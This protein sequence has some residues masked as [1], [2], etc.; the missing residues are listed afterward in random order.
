[1]VRLVALSLNTYQSTQ[2]NGKKLCI[3]VSK[4]NKSDSIPIKVK[5]WAHDSVLRNGA[6]PALIAEHASSQ[7]SE[8]MAG[9]VDHLREAAQ[10]TRHAH[11]LLRQVVRVH[12]PG[13]SFN[14]KFE[15]YW[16][17][18]NAETWDGYTFLWPSRRGRYRYRNECRVLPLI[19]AKNVT[20]KSRI[21]LTINWILIE[22][23]SNNC[24]ISNKTIFRNLPLPRR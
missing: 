22:Q 13:G 15:Y 4:R 23:S 3:F 1:M 21:F 19:T 2:I 18:S 10:H 11:Q 8:V 7:T 6:S 20:R 5:K 17:N 16:V 14:D 24:H 9:V 12:A